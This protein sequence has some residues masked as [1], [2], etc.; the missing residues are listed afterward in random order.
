MQDSLNVEN[1]PEYYHREHNV[2]GTT[3]ASFL[4]KF[5]AIYRLYSRLSIYIAWSIY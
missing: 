3:Q 4:A 1:T 2:S 5:K